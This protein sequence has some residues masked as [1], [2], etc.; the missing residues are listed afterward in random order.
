M[1][2]KLLVIAVCITV[3]EAIALLQGLDGQIFC[4]VI[5]TLA[6]IGGYSARPHINSYVQRYKSE[7]IKR[8]VL[9]PPPS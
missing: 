4:I 9:G 6:G 1:I 5:A 2:D 8:R 3:L 7:R